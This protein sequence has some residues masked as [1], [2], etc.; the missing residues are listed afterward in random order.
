MGINANNY[1]T[2]Q[3]NKRIEGATKYMLDA[4]IIIGSAL[5]C[6]NLIF[7]WFWLTELMRKKKGDSS[8]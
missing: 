7:C 8:I 5:G 4:L 3:E 1:T 6:M 2:K